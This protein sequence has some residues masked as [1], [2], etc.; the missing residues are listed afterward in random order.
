MNRVIFEQRLVL[1]ARPPNVRVIAFMIADL[2]PANKKKQEKNS[3][4][5][6]F[7]CTRSHTSIIANDHIEIFV[8]IKF[9]KC[10]THKVFD[11]NSKNRTCIFM[12][13]R[14]KF[15]NSCHIK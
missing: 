11:T 7:R 1:V 2:P 15:K 5:H 13:L 4:D 3:N 8:E 6:Q 9:Q 12:K 10:V 14:E